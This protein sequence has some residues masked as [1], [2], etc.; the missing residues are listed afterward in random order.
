M[1]MREKKFTG[2]RKRVA[3]AGET[4]PENAREGRRTVGGAGARRKSVSWNRRSIQLVGVS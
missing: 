3:E 1:Q 2:V 4:R